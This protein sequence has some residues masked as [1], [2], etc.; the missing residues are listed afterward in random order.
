MPRADA[1]LEERIAESASLVGAPLLATIIGAQ[2]FRLGKSKAEA[3]SRPVDM[4]N[5]ARIDTWR[6]VQIVPGVM[7][8]AVDLW[9]GVDHP[10]VANLSIAIHVPPNEPDTFV[11]SSLNA[12]YLRSADVS[13]S[14]VIAVAECLADRLGGLSMIASHELLELLQKKMPGSSERAA[15]A[16][17]WGIDRSGNNPAYRG[18][19]TAQISAP[20]SCVAAD[21]WEELNA[22]TA[23]QLRRV[24]EL[25]GE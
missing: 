20:F 6:R 25:L 13:W 22:P 11:I 4:D 21:S 19:E 24:A 2:W 14:S 23:S 10:G 9:N 8:Y 18:L 3:L 7:V 12:D 16:A 17:F 5:L 15:Y 1:S